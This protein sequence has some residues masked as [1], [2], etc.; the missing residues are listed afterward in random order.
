MRVAGMESGQRGQAIQLGAPLLFAILIISPSLFQTFVVPSQNGEIE[1][2]HNEQVRSQLIGYVTDID[3]DGA[4][5]REGSDVRLSAEVRDEYN[6]PASGVEVRASLDPGD[7]SSV[8]RRQGRHRYERWGRSD[9]VHVRV[10]TGPGLERRVG[11]GHRRVRPRRG[12]HVRGDGCRGGDVRDNRR[13]HHWQ[14]WRR[15]V[16]VMAHPT[17]RRQGPLEECVPHAPFDT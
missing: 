11:D 7:P 2:R 9:G 12:R 17:S 13:R 5:V 8:H 6:N 16:G 1:F 4:S 3:G 10:Q 14:R 15:M